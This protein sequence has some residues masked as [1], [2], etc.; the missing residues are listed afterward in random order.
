VV[1]VLP[2]ASVAVNV[3]VCDLVQLPVIAPLDEV[4]VGVPQASVALA[5][6]KAASIVAVEGLQ[7]AIDVA[8]PVA[9]MLGTPVSCTVTFLMHRDTSCPFFLMDNTTV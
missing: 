7:P 9:V 8:V 5:L 3:L 4:T 6:P 1:A 2:H